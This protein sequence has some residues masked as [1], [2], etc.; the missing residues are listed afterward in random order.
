MIGTAPG[1]REVVVPEINY[2]PETPQ[3]AFDSAVG[4]LTAIITHLET[5]LHARATRLDAFSRLPRTDGAVEVWLMSVGPH[6]TPVIQEMEATL[7]LD[8]HTARDFINMATVGPTPIFRGP[9]AR[10][11]RAKTS[12]EK[13]GAVV[14]IR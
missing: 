12:L 5:S 6:R 4:H 7:G 11:A 8:F 13:E 14:D 2:H 3:E 1:E 10:A 9:A